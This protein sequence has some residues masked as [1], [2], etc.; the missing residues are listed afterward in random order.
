[1]IEKVSECFQLQSFQTMK[2]IKTNAKTLTLLNYKHQ[3]VFISK[4]YYQNGKCKKSY[5]LLNISSFQIRKQLIFFWDNTDMF[6][7]SLNW[8]KFPLKLY[9]YL[10]TKFSEYL[11]REL[12]LCLNLSN[13]YVFKLF[14]WYNAYFLSFFIQF[15]PL[16]SLYGFL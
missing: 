4:K 16:P 9:N 14:L 2:T 1:M 6:T 7:C 11:L 5:F 3:C 12:W 15:K 13:F 8:E 10:W